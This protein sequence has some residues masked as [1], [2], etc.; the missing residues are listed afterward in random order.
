MPL[1]G[2]YRGETAKPWDLIIEFYNGLARTDQTFAS[3]AHLIEQIAT[4][5]REAGLCAL[6]SMSDLILGPSGDVLANPHLVISFDSLESKFILTYEDGSKKP[7]T[8][9]ASI[10]EA[11]DVVH[12]F[13][14]RRVRWYH[15]STLSDIS[16]SAG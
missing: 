2:V 1:L 6:T 4:S 14:T 7:W 11:F 8:R 5:F 16:P 9:T 10:E 15:D 12:R 13:L 3:F